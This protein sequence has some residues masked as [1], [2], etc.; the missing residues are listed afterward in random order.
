[1]S[2]ITLSFNPLNVGDDLGE[3]LKGGTV[4]EAKAVLNTRDDDYSAIELLES[5][6]GMV[7]LYCKRAR[8]EWVDD[9]TTHSVVSLTVCYPGLP[10]RIIEHR[11]EEGSVDVGVSVW[12]EGAWI[13]A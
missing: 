1:M 5:A 3:H 13:D 10:A 11:C 9:D 8:I 6:A 2:V 7:E 4:M 12:H